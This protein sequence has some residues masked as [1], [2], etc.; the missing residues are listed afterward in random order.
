MAELIDWD[1]AAA[2]NNNGVPDGFPEGMPPS[3]VNDAAREVMAVL[4]RYYEAISGAV[5]STGTASAYVLTVSQTITSYSEGQVF[6]FRA[7]ATNTASPTLSINGLGGIAL[8]INGGTAVPAGYLVTNGVYSVT[9]ANS[10]FI[11]NN[12]ID[13]P[14][15]AAIRPPPF[16]RYYPYSGVL[17]Q[18][19]A[20]WTKP[21]GLTRLVVT[22]TAGGGG[23]ESGRQLNEHGGA[24]ASSATVTAVFDA[25]D[26]AATENILVG[27]AG[28]GGTLVGPVY[29]TDGFATSF[30]TLLT[31]PG[32]NGAG[33]G[34]AAGAINGGAS[35]L[36]SAVT[37]DAS[38]LSS[39][40]IPS[41]NGAGGR[42]SDNVTNY[43]A[44]GG[45]STYGG[46]GFTRNSGLNVASSGYGSGGAGGIWTEAGG[47]AGAPGV[48]ELIEYF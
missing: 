1:V 22:A 37:I 32:A 21:A 20:T 16:R 24:G 46:A 26:L 7:H 8:Q 14:A 28:D 2:N 42:V 39:F 15:L 3:G 47:A 13:G 31:V 11:L 35:Y 23:G 38:A 41:V 33:D 27:S 17:D 44:L 34:T 30:G 10:V 19:A 43:G 40:I 5:L 48:I 12:S 4:A 25:D 36:N 6:T 29:A 9:Y 45:I 18:F